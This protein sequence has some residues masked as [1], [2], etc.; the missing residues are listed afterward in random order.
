VTPLLPHAAL[1]R[2][3]DP[4]SVAILGASPR[5]GAFALRVL[6]NLADF[7]GRVHLVNPRYERIG[8]RPCHP[9]LAALPE[10]PDC[11]AIATAREGVEELLAECAA[12]GAGGA[13]VFASGY[14]E[15][16]MAERVAQQA[17]LA[18]LARERGLPV[19]GPNCLGFG[20]F[21]TGAGVTFSAGP[22]P[23]APRLPQAAIGIV[24][25]S[26]AI[27]FALAQA[28]ERGVPVS[29]VL[30]AGNAAGADVADLTAWLVEEPG[31]HAIACVLEGLAE[32]RRLLAAAALAER[33]GKPLLVHKMA[34]GAHGAD[35]ALSHTGAIAGADAVWRAALR[36]AGAILVRD[37]GALVE[38]ALFLAKAPPVP[39][40][41][42]VAVIS[43]SGGAGVAAADAAEAH[44]VPMPQPGEAAQAVLRARIPEFGAPKNPCDATAQ[45]LNDP[46]SFSACAGALAA[47]PAFGV[48]MYPNTYAYD[49]STR[50]IP[51]L[52]ELAAA[53]SKILCV[54]WLS[55]SREG[56]GARAAEAVP[57]T[58]VFAS[59]DRCFAA[60][61]AWQARARMAPPGPPLLVPEPVRAKVAAMLR[62]APGPVLTERRAKAV[63]AAYGIPVV[64]ERLVQDAET[65][66]AAAGALGYPVVLKAES[67]ALPHKTEAG[68]V[69][70][71][72][73]DA[74]AVRRAH[75]LILARAGVPL[76]GVL[77]QPM[78]GRGVEVMLGA[79][80][81]PLFGPVAVAGLGGVMVELLRDTAPGLAPLAPETA[82][83]MLEGLQ[84][85]PL[86]A[87]FRGGP[88]VDLDRLAEILCR[89]AALA[90]DHADRIAELDMNPLICAGGG[91]MVAVD[92]LI[93]LKEPGA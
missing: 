43:T 92:A 7:R 65:A 46:E 63:L 66:V 64:E 72:L 37:L 8:E 44:G 75:A 71:D 87:G 62:E 57:G 1:R 58:A 74:D 12:I 14:A 79:R 11:V 28:V 3:L 68:V 13:V 32:P 90:A 47:D 15:T 82:R 55:E 23:V 18:A 40:A 26:G 80:Q 38:T 10:A 41:A 88:R 89:V 49:F 85:F 48:L 34:S 25:Q 22:R 81:D 42:G 93:V 2:L 67:A 17:R 20:N 31:C 52:A 69:M 39:R 51:V 54:P 61:A 86:L 30:T 6:D 35:A 27:G 5:P 56:E 29:H 50:R 84:G 19:L 73:R 83:R 59:M 16:G 53:Q 77:V 60:I 91:R 24:S 33:A 21:L 4:H 9:S 45:V 78:V 76:D 70:L 36:E